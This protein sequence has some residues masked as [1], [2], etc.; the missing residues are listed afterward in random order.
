MVCKLGLKIEMLM[1]IGFF[2]VNLGGWR[3][4]KCCG[5]INLVVIFGML[6]ISMVLLRF[7]NIWVILF[8][9]LVEI[10]IV[11]CVCILLFWV[12]LKL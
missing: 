1:L 8:C 11:F 2:V 12:K 9:L 6:L 5:V 10:I 3:V 7:L 4:V